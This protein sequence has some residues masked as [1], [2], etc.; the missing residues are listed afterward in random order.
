MQ[1]KNNNNIIILTHFKFLCLQI[2]CLHNTDV[3]SMQLT[4]LQGAGV[5]AFLLTLNYAVSKQANLVKVLSLLIV[6]Y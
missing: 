6:Y 1:V 3:F 4:L 5:I 2:V